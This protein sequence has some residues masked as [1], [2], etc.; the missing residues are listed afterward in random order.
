MKDGSWKTVPPDRTFETTREHPFYV[1][2][3]GWTPAHEIRVG[4]LLRTVDGWVPI[5]SIEDTYG[6]IYLLWDPTKSKV[7]VGNPTVTILP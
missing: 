5:K 6:K 7:P 2:G 4:D 1:K 3:K